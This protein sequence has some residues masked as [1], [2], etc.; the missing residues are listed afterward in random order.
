MLTKLKTAWKSAWMTE[1]ERE[2]LE[3][4]SPHLSTG[5]TQSDMLW[6]LSR[7]VELLNNLVGKA[8]QHSLPKDKLELYTRQLTMAK[9][10]VQLTVAAYGEFE[11]A[12]EKNTPQRYTVAVGNQGPPEGISPDD[13]GIESASPR[14]KNIEIEER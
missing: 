8:L 3:L 14:Q 9:E 13:H 12:K 4:C 5:N 11:K 1:I 7:R 10:A 6:W 2:F